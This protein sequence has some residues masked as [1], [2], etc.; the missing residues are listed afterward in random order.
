MSISIA[1]ISNFVSLLTG[2]F[3]YAV[4]TDMKLPFISGYKQ[5]VIVLFIL[6]LAMSALAGTRD[7][8]PTPVFDTMS[9]P[10]LNSLMGLGVLAVI[11]FLIMISGVKIPIISD[12]ALTF[13]LLAGIIGIKLVMTRLYFFLF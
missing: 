12:Y 2:G 3:I 8:T 11:V 4:L 13:K 1:T 6:G 10:V 9:K 7:N 5:A